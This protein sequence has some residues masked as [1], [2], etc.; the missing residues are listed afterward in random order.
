MTEIDAFVKTVICHPT[1]LDLINET[2]NSFSKPINE[3]SNEN[4]Q[5][6]I[7][8]L[9]SYDIKD[10]LYLDLLLERGLDID[11]PNNR[12]ET[13]L[14]YSARRNDV[15]YC[16]AL[17]ER[18]ADLD[19]YDENEDSPLLWATHNG[20][21][22]LV[23]LFINYG[24]DFTHKYRDGKTAIMW[25]ADQGN[26]EIFLYLLGYLGN[27]NDVDYTHSDLFDIVHTRLAKRHLSE[28]LATNRAYLIMLFSKPTW[29]KSIKETQLIH[30]ILKYYT[31]P[32]NFHRYAMY[33][34]GT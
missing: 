12:G 29:D 25:A 15:H 34:T 13:P 2:I 4:G 1:N 22:E 10:T 18:K 3:L 16:K 9:I 11:I 19:K 26:D 7:H 24:A 8:V 14:L 5:T 32:E 17:V 30:S 6:I 28:W 33:H 21:I 23:K 31:K 27:V 20:N